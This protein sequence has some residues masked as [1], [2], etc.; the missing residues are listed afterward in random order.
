ML[1]FQG[2]LNIF[3]KDFNK[4]LEDKKF[5]VQL[6]VIKDNLPA[7]HPIVKLML[8][9]DETDLAAE[10][11]LS[12]SVL[13]NK[14]D[15]I[16]LAKSGVQAIL[17]SDDPFIRFVLLSQER[18]EELKSRDNQLD[19]TDEINNQRYRHRI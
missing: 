18:L 19:N 3:P 5:V 9:N 8:D 11:L 13:S 15:V 7:E 4:N 12:K 10:M 17:S 16:E 14:E 2:I 1:Q 6:N